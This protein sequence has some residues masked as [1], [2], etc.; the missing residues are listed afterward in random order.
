M[1]CGSSCPPTF[2]PRES[3]LNA[4]P[5]CLLRAAPKYVKA[6]GDTSTSSSWGATG[7]PSTS[8]THSMRPTFLRPSST[9]QRCAPPPAPPPSMYMKFNE[10]WS[11]DAKTVVLCANTKSGGLNLL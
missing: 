8:P 11:G 9:P 3:T 2:R 1:P 4:L 7:R 6:I 10:Q 5:S